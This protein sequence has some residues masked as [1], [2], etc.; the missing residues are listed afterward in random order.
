MTRAIIRRKVDQAE[1]RYASIVAAVDALIA[2]GAV[3]AD[4]KKSATKRI[5]EAC[6]M[7][8][9]PNA[10]GATYAE[11]VW[12]YVE[13][14]KAPKPQGV[15]IEGYK[16]YIVTRDGRVY[17]TKTE[18]YLK[19]FRGKTCYNVELHEDSKGTT[20]TV[21]ELVASA[22]MPNPDVNKYRFLHHKDGN[23]ANNDVTNLLWHETNR[24][25][26]HKCFNAPR[27]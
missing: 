5:S 9:A 6:S 20:R 27:K 24:L 1:V 16:H 25:P 14:K 17:N 7:N 18:Q 8:D 3:T 11:F 19:P 4:E 26:D 21:H 23:Y 15:L 12:K 13:T 22:Y 2:E 10:N